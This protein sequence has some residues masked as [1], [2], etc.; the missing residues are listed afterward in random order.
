V[1]VEEE[2]QKPIT[3]NLGEVFFKSFSR[4]TSLQHCA[5]APKVSFQIHEEKER[6]NSHGKASC[7]K[8]TYQ[9]TSNI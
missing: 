9:E 2:L 1:E 6:E 5:L 3:S 4:R 8:E 7:T